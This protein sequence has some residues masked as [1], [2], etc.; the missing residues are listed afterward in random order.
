MTGPF[1]LRNNC[2]HS[3][4]NFLETT[5]WTK[6]HADFIGY[7]RVDAS[8]DLDATDPLMNNPVGDDFSIPL[9][10]PCARRGVGAGVTKDVD[11]N[12]FCPYH[13]D[14]GAKS[15][16]VTPWNLVQASALK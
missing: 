10:S 4:T 11:G 12:P 8:G 3:Y 7:D 2:F 14:I 5:T 15:T 9:T 1:T 13:P 6:T 16:G